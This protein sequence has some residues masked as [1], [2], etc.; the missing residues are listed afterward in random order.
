MF[1]N[2]GKWVDD[3]L[4]LDRRALVISLQS[5]FLSDLAY[6]DETNRPEAGETVS[7]DS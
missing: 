3:P 5:M 4:L 2:A 7:Y 6:F 1:K